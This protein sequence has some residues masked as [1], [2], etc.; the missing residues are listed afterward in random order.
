MRP[1]V[2]IRRCATLP[3]ALICQG[4]LR[5]NGIHSSVDDYYHAA[6]VW[7]HVPALNGVSLSVAES[8]Y[9]RSREL[10]I[11]H[12]TAG[13]EILDQ[14]FGAYEPPR[15]YG[16]I[17]AWYM[18]LDYTLHIPRLILAFLLTG[19]F[20]LLDHFIPETWWAQADTPTSNGW[21][22][23]V[24][25][26]TYDPIYSTTFELEGILFVIVIVLVFLADRLIKPESETKEDIS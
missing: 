13:S 7:W 1:T 5:A 4:L 18:L 25:T 8:D 22:P 10:L 24:R 19:L 3:E 21:I 12:A 20:S 17:A 15:R 6:N 23:Q 2:V 16:V 11:E 14:E 9:T 26:G